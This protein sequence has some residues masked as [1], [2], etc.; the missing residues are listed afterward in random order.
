M[1]SSNLSLCHISSPSAF[2]QEHGVQDYD[3]YKE[4]TS[5]IT[6]FSQDTV[7]ED[8]SENRLW[9]F[10][11]RVSL[12]FS[13][14]LQVQTTC[15]VKLES[16]N[17]GIWNLLMKTNVLMHWQALS[18]KTAFK[19]ESSFHFCYHGEQGRDFISPKLIDKLY[20]G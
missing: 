1:L 13:L 19:I 3:S 6:R 11:H 9:A 12:S 10:F 20:F 4:F 2:D 17:C 16:M 15:H 7:L 14:L 8:Q 5:A 18:L